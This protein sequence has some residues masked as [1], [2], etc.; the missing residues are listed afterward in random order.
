MSNP[1]SSLSF[2]VSKMHL[3]LPKTRQ[4]NDY[5]RTDGTK[6]DLIMYKD[7]RFITAQ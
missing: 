1:Q 2:A 7:V 6:M 3:Y 5:N 4:S